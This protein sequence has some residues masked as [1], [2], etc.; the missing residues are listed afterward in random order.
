MT[1]WECRRNLAVMLLRIYRVHDACVWALPC[2]K[3]KTQERRAVVFFSRFKWVLLYYSNNY[4]YC[5]LLLD[6][7][8]YSV[9]RRAPG[10]FLRVCHLCFFAYFFVYIHNVLSIQVLVD[11]R[12]KLRN[13]VS[14][15]AVYFFLPLAPLWFKVTWIPKGVVFVTW[16]DH[17]VSDLIPPLWMSALGFFFF[18]RSTRNS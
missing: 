9:A 18:F 17:C 16:G 10:H 1:P 4:F 13:R 3:K 15:R 7:V 2:G 14:V 5:L 6:Q 11:R 12:D 8:L